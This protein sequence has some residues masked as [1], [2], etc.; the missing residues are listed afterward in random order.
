MQERTS[1][2][3][4]FL[5][6]FTVCTDGGASLAPAAAAALDDEAAGVRN[7]TC[8][9]G[10]SPAAAPTD[11]VG[12]GVIGSAYVSVRCA[13]GPGDAA[14]KTDLDLGA[15]ENRDEN[16]AEIEQT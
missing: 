8:T 14:G 11:G 7:A 1:L 12:P 16:A 2:T 13:S 6:F 10:V 3:M 15:I 4:R 5:L 9:A